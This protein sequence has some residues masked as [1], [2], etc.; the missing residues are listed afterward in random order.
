MGGILGVEKEWY[1]IPEN[2]RK[3]QIMKLY[4]PTKRMI[5]LLIKW[6]NN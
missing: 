5:T 1:D 2:K 4:I 6:L 3:H